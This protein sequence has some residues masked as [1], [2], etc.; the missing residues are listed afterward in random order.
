MS[1]PQRFRVESNRAKNSFWYTMV[2]GNGNT[3]M[4]SKTK[5]DDYDNALRAARDRALALQSTDI[6]VEFEHDG[7]VYEE[8]YPSASVEAGPSDQPRG[9]K[10]TSREAV[11]MPEPSF[12][13]AQS[14][15]NPNS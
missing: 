4:T 15:L 14:L 9:Y 1:N 2:A 13:V 8:V 11:A 6:V 12:A 10:R 7:D 3:V 5:Y